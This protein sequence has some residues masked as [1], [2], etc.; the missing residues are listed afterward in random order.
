MDISALHTFITLA[1]VGHMTRT[2]NMLHLTQPAVSAQLSKLE[3]EVGHRL[4][5]RTAK[6]MVL[7]QA[8]Q[9]YLQHVEESLKWLKDGQTALE[10][11]TGLIRGQLAI[12]GG[13]TA[14][15]YLFPPTLGQFHLE[16]PGI[17]MFVREQGS[18][19]VVE[20][21]LKGELDLGVVT[22]PIQVS[23][24]KLHIEP[25]IEDELRLIVP[26]THKLADKKR[27][28]WEDLHEQP[29]VLF[30]AGSAVRQLI[31][32]RLQEQAI[33]TNIVMELRSIESIKQMVTQGIGAAFVSQFALERAQHALR[34]SGS[35][36]TRQLAIVWRAD[37]RLSQASARFLEMLLADH[38]Q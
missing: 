5:D 37:R 19:H 18:E 11:L 30:E 20:S 26:P 28:K 17:R 31:D 27:F 38:A 15:T 36:L 24:S 21:I 22:L 16:Y 3:T 12:G 4:F 23:A 14:T 9:V 7:T 35:P 13:A 25:W 1:R 10:E 8:G 6:G 33:T 2:A 34:A 29:L 32:Q